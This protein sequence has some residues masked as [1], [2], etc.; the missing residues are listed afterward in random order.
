MF[1]ILT[2]IRTRIRKDT[3]RNLRVLLIEVLCVGSLELRFWAE[4]HAICDNEDTAAFLTAAHI[5]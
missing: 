4:F 1:L 5:H 3:V 2:P